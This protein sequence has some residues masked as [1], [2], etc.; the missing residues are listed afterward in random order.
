[1]KSSA[2]FRPFGMTRQAIFACSAS[3]LLAGGGCGSN[4]SAALPSNDVARTALEGALNAWR[5][6]GKPGAIEGTNPVVQVTDTPWSQGDKLASYEIVKEDTSG[7]EKKFTVR[8]SLTKPDRVEEVEYH[9][10][11]QGPVMVLRDQDYQ[12]NV[13][14][15]DGPKAS[16]PGAQKSYNRK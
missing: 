3:L 15:E 12:R 9:V 8:L 10:M 14:M 2:I 5:S 4:G 6:G 11:G 1:M 13:N 16:K 7:A